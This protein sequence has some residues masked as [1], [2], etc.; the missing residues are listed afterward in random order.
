MMS[1]TTVTL[2]EVLNKQI[3]NL[4]VLYTKLHNYHWYVKGHQ[5]FTLHLKFEELYNEVALHSDD[6]AERLLAIKGLPMARMVDYLNYS[7]VKEATGTENADQMV[8]TIAQDFEIMIVELRGGM[9]LAESLND[10]T[11][12]DMLLAIHT[13]LEKHVW[14]LNSFLE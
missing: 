6:L 12:A 10:D 7:S 8:K 9:V 5:F 11:T 3:A 14:M 13:S 1:S 4:N 2:Q